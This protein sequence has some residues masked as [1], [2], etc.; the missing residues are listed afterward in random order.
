MDGTDHRSKDGTDVGGEAQELKSPSA[1][2]VFETI[3]KEGEDELDRRPRELA[4]SAL[5]CGLSMGF[6]LL[7]QSLIA[8]HLPEASWAKLVGAFGY[9]FGFIIVVLGRQQ[10]FTETR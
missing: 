5:A 1:H 2:I 3:R 9:T 8:A 4:F 10:L 6:S 7:A